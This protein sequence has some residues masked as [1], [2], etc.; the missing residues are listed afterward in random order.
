MRHFRGSLSFEFKTLASHAFEN[1]LP[2]QRVG[3]FSLFVKTTSSSYHN[4]FKDP[5]WFSLK[6]QE[7]KISITFEGFNFWG[8]TIPNGFQSCQF[9]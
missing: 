5:L 8:K 1:Q 4:H 9:S 7:E 3:R 6:K 2:S